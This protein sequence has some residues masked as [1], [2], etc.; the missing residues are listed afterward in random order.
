[1]ALLLDIA[2][3]DARLGGKARSLA[4]L[5]EHGLP[6]PAG[7]VIS[8]DLFRALC[9][10]LPV[11]Q[12]LD[13]DALTLLDGWR[14]QLGEA[15][16][17]D[18]FRDQL[19][20]RLD[21]LA[22]ERLAVRSSF[23]G[24][25]RLGSLAAGVYES[26][27]DVPP[28]SVEQAIR[29]VLASALAPGAAAYALA[30]GEVPARAP[31]AVLVHAYI[32]GDAEGSAALVPGLADGPLVTVRRGE[33]TAAA[34][35]EIASAL[36]AL[37][38]ARGPCEVEWVVDAGRVLYL[39][40][41]PFQAPPAAKSWPGWQELDDATP[42]ARAVWHWD[43]AHN[44]LPLSP[45]QAGLVELV[46]QRC[47]IGIR[48]RVLGGYLFYTRDEQPLPPA[49]PCE[50]AAAF[51]VQLR[52]AVEGRL[53]A[54]GEAPS[55]EAALDTFV[56]AYQPIFGVLQPSLRQAHARLRD[57]LAV[58][59]PAGLPLLPA[60]LGGVASMA[61]ERLDRA[62]RLAAATTA[63]EREPALA[64]YLGLF[65]D[66]AATWDIAAPTYAEDPA[67]LRARLPLPASVP[68]PDWRRAHAEVE[69]M[70]DP[71]LSEGF[72]TLLAL[73]RAAVG[74]GEDDDWLYA[75]TQT[76]V[77][78][79]LLVL[80]RRWVE[81]GALAEVGDVFYLPLALLRDIAG[82]KLAPTD[83]PA[84][85]EAGRK[86]WQASLAS[87]PPSVA[88]SER[89]LL[90]GLGTGGRAIG[91][92]ALHR[93]GDVR[94]DTVLVARTLLPTELPLLSAIALVTETGG[95]LDHVAAQ[96]RERGIPAVVSARGA[97]ESL[98]DGDPVL[99]DGEQGLVVKLNGPSGL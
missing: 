76:A 16:W 81:A 40:A 82:G 14:G 75:R 13:Q 17:P 80:G 62:A 8:D 61:S 37:V 43:A 15:P 57:F 39:Q 68:A 95:V 63:E 77:R 19:H 70:L 97:T 29:E 94:A 12:Q 23:A 18:G 53:V 96:A 67:A 79:A 72:P 65:G 59:A 60:L 28:G 85:A 71:D 44:P 83:L 55:L 33:L 51:W 50:D 90:H 73:A 4:E 10:A 49:I 84:R 5:A 38:A 32:P 42:T 7:F 98:A 35:E 86:A 93:P 21:A 87:P 22:A 66:E 26:R 11:V 48:Q 78:R 46:D 52:S 9:P 58:H 20:G 74:L 3:G 64:D 54:M 31:L 89:G 91:R 69:A 56:Q 24:E 36:A 6:T 41:R 99:V 45:A 92:V 1:M 2:A 47:S 30:H 25:D 27:L 88:E 34:G